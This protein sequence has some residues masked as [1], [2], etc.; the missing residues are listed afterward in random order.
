MVKVRT[1]QA[2][3]PA[4]ACTSRIVNAQI[5]Q[6]RFVVPSTLWGGALVGPE[7][8]GKPPV[9]GKKMPR[10]DRLNVSPALAWVHGETT[11]GIH[12]RWELSPMTL[13]RYG[14][15]IMTLHMAL[16]TTSK[17]STDNLIVRCLCTVCCYCWG[18]TGDCC[19]GLKGG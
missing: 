9:R 14:C 4:E 15:R 17:F 12:L 5:T 2:H 1:A 16:M 10:F 3:F 13:F 8:A 19:W 7:H 11:L 18:L 6:Q